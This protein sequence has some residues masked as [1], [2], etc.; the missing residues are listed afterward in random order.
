MTKIMHKA[1]VLLTEYSLV[2]VF[3]ITASFV[4]FSK[5]VNL[6]L[7][8]FDIVALA[9]S[10]FLIYF[11]DHFFDKANNPFRFKYIPPKKHPLIKPFFTLFFLGAFFLLFNVSYHFILPGIVIVAFVLLYF[12]LLHYS[13]QNYLK[14]FKELFIAIVV[15]LVVTILPMWVAGKFSFWSSLVFGLL[16]FQNTLFFSLIDKTIDSKNNTPNIIGEIGIKRVKTILIFLG[17]SSILIFIVLFITYGELNNMEW[18]LIIMQLF[19]SVFSFF[20]I[21]K[22]FPYY[23]KL[24]VDSMFLIPVIFTV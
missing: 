14:Y 11:L 13:S 20:L 19:F 7:T 6:D 5:S 12:F 8:I 9:Y 2:V 3:G 21:R 15:T 4:F 1:L 23:T 10:L 24:V 22:S 16:C 18:M 17:T